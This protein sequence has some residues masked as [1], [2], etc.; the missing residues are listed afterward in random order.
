VVTGQFAAALATCDSEVRWL[1]DAVNGN[2]L[3]A[4]KT[5]AALVAAP[6][7]IIRIAVRERFKVLFEATCAAM[8]SS[9]PAHPGELDAT[10][11]SKLPCSLLRVRF[12]LFAKHGHE[13]EWPQQGENYGER[14]SES[15]QLA[16]GDLLTARESVGKVR[17]ADSAHLA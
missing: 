14:E 4:R 1:T 11:N 2:E 6:L 3:P 17:S 10:L 9:G 13:N 8:Y 16:F 5:L 15:E 12:S 7:A